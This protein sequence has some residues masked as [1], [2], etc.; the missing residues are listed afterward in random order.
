[1]NG[2]AQR[3]AGESA[4]VGRAT[5]PLRSHRRARATA[6]TRPW[7]ASRPCSRPRGSVAGRSAHQQPPWEGPPPPPC[8]RAPL[9]F[10]RALPRSGQVGTWPGGTPLAWPLACRHGPPAPPRAGRARRGA[11]CA[12]CASPSALAAADRGGAPSPRRGGVTTTGKRRFRF[13]QG[14]AGCLRVVFFRG[15]LC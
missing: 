3:P 15:T 14:G 13:G 6:R 1:M 7:H 4:P 11:F 9:F 12:A 5:G 10:P 2:T 8:N